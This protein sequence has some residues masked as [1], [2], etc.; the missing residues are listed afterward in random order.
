MPNIIGTI[1]SVERFLKNEV[2]PIF[3]HPTNDDYVPITL[4]QNREYVIPDFQREIRWKKENIIEL[5]SNISEGGRF[6]GNIILSKRQSLKYEIIDGQ[7]RITVLLMLLK[8]ITY[9]SG[10]SVDVYS[11]CKFS[12]QSFSEFQNLL[13]HNFAY[14]TMLPEEQELVIES[15]IFN[16]RLRYQELWKA[17]GDS[18]IITRGNSRN[19][20]TNLSRC[21]LNILLNTVTDG[22][23]SIQYFLDVNLKGVRLDTEDIL[24][25]YLFS[26]D[27]G[28]EIRTAWKNVKRSIHEIKKYTSKYT[29]VKA[30]EQFLYCNLFMKPLFRNSGVKFNENFQL[31]SSKTINGVHYYK[32]DHIVKV[33]NDNEYFRMTFDALNK[34]LNAYMDIVSTDGVSATFRSM[35]IIGRKCLIQDNEIKIIH[36]LLKKI[37]LDDNVVPKIL[38]MKYLLDIFILSAT[39]NKIDIRKAYGIYCL[40]ILFTV[41][42][43]KRSSTQITDIAKMDDWYIGVIAQINRYLCSSLTDKRLSAKYTALLLDP[44]DSSASEDD[45][46]TEIEDSVAINTYQ[47]R[48]KS[49]ATIYNYFRINDGNVSIR[50]IDCLYTYLNDEKLFSTEHFI[51]N[52][53]EKYS[54]PNISENVAYPDGVKKCVDS[55]FNFVFMPRELNGSWGNMHISDKLIILAKNGTIF[56]CEYSQMV[57][58]IC[59]EEFANKPDVTNL[60]HEVAFEQAYAEY[61]ESDFLS[62][63]SNYARKVIERVVSRIKS[64]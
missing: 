41:F 30:V 39:R 45:E 19:F 48:C 47:Y 40:S 4:E 52:K 59:Q 10:A 64:S 5:I 34:Y 15:D 24:K 18:G 46:W 42:D 9:V 1:V 60:K 54:I 7:Q 6:L 50:H 61:Y 22:G 25:S 55:L 27:P 63:F 14:D 51:L 11:T 32:N 62:D 38:V 31:K 21:E 17:I 33:I 8:Y 2:S 35:F 53:S 3:I 28:E 58:E 16:Q 57:F 12:I 56:N 13:D 20:L 26:F 29:L 49:L 43:D 23:Y 36:N 37:L 44:A